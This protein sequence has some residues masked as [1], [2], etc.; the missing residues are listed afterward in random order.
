[1]Q[2]YFFHNNFK[3]PK[4]DVISEDNILNFKIL[5]QKEQWAAL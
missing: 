1:M 5:S 4:S 3:N 2:I